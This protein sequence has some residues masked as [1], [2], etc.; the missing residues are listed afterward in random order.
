M[1]D[2]V[3]MEILE[4][5]S[6]LWKER[7]YFLQGHRVGRRLALYAVSQGAFGSICGDQIGHILVY[8]HLQERQ[9]MRMLEHF[10]QAGFLEKV[11]LFLRREG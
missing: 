4:Y 10:E 8:A 2:I 1:S 11:K 6:H 3:V 5:L 7:D 9:K